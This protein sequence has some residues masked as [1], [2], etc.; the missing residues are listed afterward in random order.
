MAIVSSVVLGLVI[1]TLRCETKANRLCYE[2][3]HCNK[4]L[5]TWKTARC[6]GS[7]VTK[8]TTHKFVEPEKAS[9][10]L[11]DFLAKAVLASRPM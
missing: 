1:L 7:C 6:N 2:C 10:H 5:R 3:F 11:Y 4:I 8:Q 9:M